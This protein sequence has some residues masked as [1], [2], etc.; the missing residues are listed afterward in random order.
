[1]REA[2]TIRMMKDIETKRT[3]GLEKDLKR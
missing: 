3:D 1:M 2:S